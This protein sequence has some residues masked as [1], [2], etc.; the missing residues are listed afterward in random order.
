MVLLIVLGQPWQRQYNCRVSWIKEDFLYEENDQEFFEPFLGKDNYA[1]SD[2]ND[3]EGNTS[4]IDIQQYSHKGK[5][6]AVD[7]PNGTPKAL[8]S[9][10]L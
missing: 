6:K 5:E 1:N 4:P 2:S 9:H 7:I 8:M 3:N 10:H